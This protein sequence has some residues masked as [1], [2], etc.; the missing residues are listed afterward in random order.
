MHRLWLGGHI[1]TLRSFYRGFIDAEWALCVACGKG[2]GGRHTCHYCPVH[3][4]GQFNVLSLALSLSLF[5][6]LSTTWEKSRQ[7]WAMPVPGSGESGWQ[8]HSFLS[9]RAH[10]SSLTHSVPPLC[11]CLSLFPSLST[12]SYLSSTSMWCIL[13]ACFGEEDPFYASDQAAV[14][15]GIVQ[16]TI[17]GPF[18]STC[19]YFRLQVCTC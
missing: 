1:F 4:L 16:V 17:S 10:D 2:W 18:S 12:N 9:L 15:Q 11:P 14:K 3:S 19:I 6:G 7:M 8:N 13:K 5:P